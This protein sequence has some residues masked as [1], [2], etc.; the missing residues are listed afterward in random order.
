MKYD[1]S[2]TKKTYYCERRVVFAVSSFMQDIRQS[3]PLEEQLQVLMDKMETANQQLTG[4]KQT[5]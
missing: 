4:G 1:S 5:F 2:G 3:M